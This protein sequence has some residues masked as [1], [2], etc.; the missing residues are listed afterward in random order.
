MIIKRMKF[1]GMGENPDITYGFRAYD[2][3]TQT[4]SNILSPEEL[5]LEDESFVRLI[6]DKYADDTFTEMFSWV[7]NQT[8]IIMVDD[9]EYKITFDVYGWNMVENK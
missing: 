3:E 2:G 7:L 8:N 5:K 1:V 9:I 6:I 4:Y